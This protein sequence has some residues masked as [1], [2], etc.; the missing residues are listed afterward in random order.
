MHARGKRLFFCPKCFGSR[1]PNY[2]I[3]PIPKKDKLWTNH[4]SLLGLNSAGICKSN[5]GTWAAETHL[6][7][8]STRAVAH[9]WRRAMQRTAIGRLCLGSFLLAIVLVS[10]S[11]GQRR[12]GYPKPP[13][14]P[15]ARD[16]PTSDTKSSH[17]LDTFAMEREAR[18]LSALAS[19]IPGDVEQLK[20]G[21]LPSD[22][23]DKLKRIEE[24]SKQLRGQIRPLA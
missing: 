21:L 3:S 22:A 16:E 8:R 15:V 11:S 24:L 13:G 4:P 7:R 9:L 5:A 23:V 17:R 6:C 18:E 20:R 12:R 10:G 19:S 2:P 1:A 14:P